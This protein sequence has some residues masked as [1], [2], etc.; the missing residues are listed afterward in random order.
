MIGFILTAILTVL[1]VITA[2]TTS[3][4][5]AEWLRYI[6]LNPLFWFGA[7]GMR[8]TWKRWRHPGHQGNFWLSWLLPSV[9]AIL[10][11]GVLVLILNLLIALSLSRVL[12]GTT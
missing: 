12:Q 7:F 10:V 6:L 9:V 4:A 1:V 5:P 3:G 8:W 11:F 2:L